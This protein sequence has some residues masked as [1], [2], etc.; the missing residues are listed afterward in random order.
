MCLLSSFIIVF[1][2]PASHLGL[3]M[4]NYSS[5]LTGEIFQYEHNIT[6]RKGKE[7]WEPPLCSPGFTCHLQRSGWVQRAERVSRGQ[8]GPFHHV[9]V[10]PAEKSVVSQRELV[11]GDELAA[12][13]HATETLDVVDFGAGP[14]HEV[15]FAEADV[16]FSTFDPV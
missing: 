4:V 5:K 12:A 10:G 13:G 16:A 15:V 9:M 8:A 7:C 1:N 3:A 14:H 6:D 11:P 2:L